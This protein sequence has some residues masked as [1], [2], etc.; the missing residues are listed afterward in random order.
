MYLKLQKKKQ[1]NEIIEFIKSSTQKLLSNFAQPKTPYNGLLIWHDVGV[2]KTCSALSIAENFRDYALQQNKK[3]LILTPG[4][5]LKQ[6]W[7]KEIFNI[8]KQE[9]VESQNKTINVQ[10]TGNYYTQKYKELKKKFGTSK[11]KKKNSTFYT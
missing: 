6:S 2:G 5:K 10:C 4:S 3:I 7:L 11:A 1:N 9:F 8:N